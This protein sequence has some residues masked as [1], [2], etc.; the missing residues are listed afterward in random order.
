MVAENGDLTFYGIPHEPIRPSEHSKLMELDKKRDDIKSSTQNDIDDLDLE[1]VSAL[2]ALETL[3]ESWQRE[4][5]PLL[6][7]KCTPRYSP[8]HVSQFAWNVPHNQA[9]TG[10]GS[11]HSSIRDT[12]ES[13][14]EMEI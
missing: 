2:E 14:T 9:L 12:R 11:Q 13:P 1:E 3:W 6:W 7:S 4:S 10:I 5:F 8:V